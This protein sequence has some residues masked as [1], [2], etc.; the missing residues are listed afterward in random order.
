MDLVR[1]GQRQDCRSPIIQN[2]KILGTELAGYSVGTVEW[3][4]K[5]EV[6]MERS[7]EGGGKGGRGHL[8]AL[9]GE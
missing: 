7:G 4:G 9:H 2:K 1:D 3:E 5:P 6:Q 8:R